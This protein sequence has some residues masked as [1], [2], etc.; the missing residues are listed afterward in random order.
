MPAQLVSLAP[1]TETSHGV[2]DRVGNTLQPMLNCRGDAALTA[3]LSLLLHQ[4]PE[5]PAQTPTPENL[6]FT[7]L[8]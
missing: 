7:R 8:N 1:L 5:V 2:P 6:C 3:G 4:L